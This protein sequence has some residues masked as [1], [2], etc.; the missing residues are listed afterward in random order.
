MNELTNGAIYAWN[1]EKLS[2]IIHYSCIK[3]NQYQTYCQITRFSSSTLCYRAVHMCVSVALS[4]RFTVKRQHLFIIVLSCVLSISQFG[5][6]ARKKNKRKREKRTVCWTG[7]KSV[8]VFYV[9]SIWQNNF[10]CRTILIWTIVLCV[11]IFLFSTQ[12]KKQIDRI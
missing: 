4:L 5:M 9:Q 7:D 6:A 2:Y 3:L 1:G 12:K 11:L 8:C 10:F